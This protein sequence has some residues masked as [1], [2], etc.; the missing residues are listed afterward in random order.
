MT[1]ATMMDRPEALAVSAERLV[2][3]GLWGQVTGLITMALLNR[4]PWGFTAGA[5]L[6][7]AGA[8]ASTSFVGKK[9]VRRRGV[10]ATATGLAACAVLAAVLQ[11]GEDV[12]VTRVLLWAPVA[13]VIAWESGLWNERLAVSV[14]AAACR[15]ERLRQ[16]SIV[17]GHGLVAGGLLASFLRLEP[18]GAAAPAQVVV[19]VALF[20]LS[21]LFLGWVFDALG[22]LAL[23]SRAAPQAARPARGWIAMPVLFVL[24]ALVLTMWA[25]PANITSTTRSLVKDRALTC[26][27]QYDPPALP[28]RTSTIS[29]ALDDGGY[30]GRIGPFDVRLSLTSTGEGIYFERSID[31]RGLGSSG[32]STGRYE[33]NERANGLGTLTGACLPA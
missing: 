12:V 27:L 29:I 5:L 33:I 8:T 17:L 13:G 15:W 11:G 18:R 21:L 10:I 26:H 16:R 28:P 20:A 24:S 3:A 6:F 7:A 4:S 23:T 1:A 32:D 19:S 14:A 25:G 22:T 31:A 30:A 9:D 2:V